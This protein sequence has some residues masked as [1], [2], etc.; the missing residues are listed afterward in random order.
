MKLGFVVR[1]GPYTSQNIDTAYE[2][3]KRALAKGHSVEIFLYEDGV[4]SMNKYI[5]SPDERNIA[6]RMSELIQSGARITGCGLCAKFRGIKKDMIIENTKLSGMA[7][8]S[9]LVETSDK[10]ITLSF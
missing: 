6:G 4:L 7:V 2:L 3:A 1:T 8:L 5:N 9:K 10:V